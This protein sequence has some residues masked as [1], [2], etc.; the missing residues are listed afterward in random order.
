MMVNRFPRILLLLTLVL[1]ASCCDA[2]QLDEFASDGCSLFPDRS[3]ISDDDWCSCCF[4]HDKAYWQG[5]G[6]GKRYI[7]DQ[8]L[9]SCVLAKTGSKVLAG[10][11]FAGVRV[12][13]SPYLYTWFR[14][15][16]GW[17]YGRWY[18]PLTRDE[19]VEIDR[20]LKDFA[21]QETNPVC[22]K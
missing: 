2:A 14:W 16:Y 9:Q 20:A 4:A 6:E 22:G 3:W 1:R 15:G 18:K 13:G 5:G 17:Q 7:A 21:Q 19:Q 8:E 11:M 10:L 12:G